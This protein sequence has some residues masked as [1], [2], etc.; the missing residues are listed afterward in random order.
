MV[1]QAGKDLFQLRCH[2]KAQV[3]GDLGA[4]FSGGQ[5]LVFLGASINGRGVAV[6]RLAAGQQLVVTFG[7]LWCVLG[8]EEERGAHRRLI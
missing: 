4:V 3:T 2:E 7:Q 6:R 1:G 8:L 5:G